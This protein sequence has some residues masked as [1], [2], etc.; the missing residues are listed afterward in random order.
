MKATSEQSK[1]EPLRKKIIQEIV[2]FVSLIVFLGTATAFTAFIVPVTGAQA[3]QHDPDPVAADNSRI[4]KR[5][6][7]QS[8]LTPEDQSRGSK[9]DI[10]LTRKIRERLT[11]DATLSAYGK[12]V[13]IITLQGKATLRGP[14]PSREE[15]LFIEKV[16]RH[17]TGN[18]VN[19]KLEIVTK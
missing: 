13:K 1:N 5:D 6:V 8:T 4:N 15:S 3:E 2:Y 14:V 18:E 17:V 19:N 12:N 16:A 9:K 11:R 10:E 7:M